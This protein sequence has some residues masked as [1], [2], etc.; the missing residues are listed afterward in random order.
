[1]VGNGGMDSTSLNARGVEAY[2][3]GQVAAARE[4]LTQAATA[5]SASAMFNLG[6]LLDEVGDSAGARE[7]YEQAALAGDGNAMRNL[8][9]VYLDLDD[10]QEA[11]RWFEAAVE[12]GNTEAL[13]NL[14]VV[15]VK[16]GDTQGALSWFGQ[17]A[18]AGNP[19]AMSNLGLLLEEKGDVSVATN[20]Y[21]RAADAGNVRATRRLAQAL[22]LLLQEGEII[23][24]LTSEWKPI[25]LF[26]TPESLITAWQEL[27]AKDARQAVNSFGFD[28][29]M[30]SVLR[31]LPSVCSQHFREFT[32]DGVLAGQIMYAVFE[33]DFE[34]FHE[35]LIAYFES[36]SEESSLAIEESD[37]ELNRWWD[38]MRES[39]RRQ[40]WSSTQS[41]RQDIK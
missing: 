11:K 40:I 9:F 26:E 32:P 16:T 31:S 14:G 2:R 30:E 7:W 17:G 34:A 29:F 1:M 39:A 19:E 33:S 22:L 38:E 12:A 27:N 18:N 15:C 35:T 10:L 5:G 28:A 4:L 37:T 21:E 3:A 8:G 24:E 6:A 13:N 25:M 41:L 23:A 36:I 20:W